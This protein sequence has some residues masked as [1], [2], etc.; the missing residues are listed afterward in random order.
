MRRTQNKREGQTGLVRGTA[1]AEGW[2]IRPGQSPHL[3]PAGEIPSAASPGLPAGGP[4]LRT[5]PA[6][7]VSG[8]PVPV[9]RHTAA[10]ACG[11]QS[12]AAWPTALA[13][14]IARLLCGDGRAA[15]GGAHGPP[16]T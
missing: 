1:R 3:W 7:L 13:S 2:P 11:A 9:R 6:L 12:P 8:P 10:S 16:E 5:L 15:P 14:A 4:T